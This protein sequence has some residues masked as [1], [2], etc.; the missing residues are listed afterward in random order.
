MRRNYPKGL[1]LS[2][3]LSFSFF[4]CVS[5]AVKYTYTCVYCE[6]HPKGIV[7]FSKPVQ[8]ARHV[9]FDAHSKPLMLRSTDPFGG[10]PV[11][12]SASFVKLV[13]DSRDTR[14][15]EGKFVMTN[16]GPDFGG[17]LL[18]RNEVASESNGEQ[19]S[20]TIP[21]ACMGPK[22]AVQ[23]TPGF[24]DKTRDSKPRSPR[25]AIPPK[26]GG[27]RLSAEDVGKILKASNSTASSN[28]DMAVS[29]MRNVGQVFGGRNQVHFSYHLTHVPDRT[30]TAAC[31][32]EGMPS[33]LD[34][35][36]KLS[37]FLFN[38]S[39]SENCKSFVEIKASNEAYLQK[40]RSNFVV[41]LVA[42]EAGP[43]GGREQQPDWT[44]AHNSTATFR[45]TFCRLRRWIAEFYTQACRMDDSHDVTLGVS[46]NAYNM[47][48]PRRT[49]LYEK[50]FEDVCKRVG[51]EVVERFN[52]GMRELASDASRMLE[53]ASQARYCQGADS[54]PPLTPLDT[55]TTPRFR[56]SSGRKMRTGGD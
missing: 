42:R 26:S 9:A 55:K 51:R 45:N 28:Y 52:E 54:T 46:P 12:D 11:P 27:D 8:E 32:T 43:G 50:Y 40:F 18:V 15:L 44:K 16:G 23:G 21:K 56:Y 17:T 19:V 13:G 35:T 6:S 47:C 33:S 30:A 3:S 48:K 20:Q 4:S 37:A 41:V 1:L 22:V 14:L 39:S 5:C 10:E 7:V 34:I 2:L 29:V 53:I 31:K 25:G 49:T 36:A 38:K 24:V